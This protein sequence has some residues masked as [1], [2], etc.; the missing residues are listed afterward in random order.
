MSATQKVYEEQFKKQLKFLENF[1]DGFALPDAS[2][3]DGGLELG[4]RVGIGFGSP[5][6]VIHFVAREARFTEEEIQAEAEL[7]QSNGGRISIK[8]L[9]EHRAQRG[10]PEGE[11][12]DE[13]VAASNAINEQMH[14]EGAYVTPLE[15]HARQIASMFNS[16]AAQYN[17]AIS[18]DATKMPLPP[19]IA[20]A[21]GTSLHVNLERLS[22]ILEDMPQIV[23]MLME[24]ATTYTVDVRKQQVTGQIEEAVEQQVGIG[25]AV[26]NLSEQIRASDPDAFE[27]ARVARETHAPSWAGRMNTGEKSEERS[28]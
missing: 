19:Q 7:V 18:G 4:G 25:R 27:R 28:R 14:E 9:I 15:N 17:E 12:L 20:S 10:H 8:E 1:T 16:I 11:R 22:S 6:A 3:L 13:I 23:P 5:N 24:A 21:D 26:R 2:V